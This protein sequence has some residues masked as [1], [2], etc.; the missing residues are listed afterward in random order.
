M[1][2]ILKN[3]KQ[4]NLTTLF[5]L[6]KF[7]RQMIYLFALIAIIVANL[8]VSPFALRLD[9]SQGQAYTLSSS[10]RKILKD[11][12]DVVNIKFFASSDLPTRILP[13]KNEV[14][15]LLNEYKKTGGKNIQLKILDPKKDTKAQDEAKE[16][17]VPELQFSQLEKDKYAV[18]SSYLGISLSYG[19]KKE[20]LP[21][22]TDVD[23]LEYNLTAAI[24]KMTRKELVKIGIL[25]YENVFDPQQDQ[26]STFKKILQQQFN[27]EFVN[28][29]SKSATAKIDPSIK[30]IM[31]FDTNQKEYDEQETNA[32]K[33]YVNNGGKAIFF[34]DGVWVSE[35]LTTQ[36]AKHNLFS[37]LKNFG[38]TLEKNLILSTTS[39][40]VSFGSQQVSFLAP[41]PFWVKSSN[42]N[43]KTSHFSNIQVLTYPWVSSLSL[44]KKSGGE[45]K[46]LVKTS[47]ESWQQKDDFTLNPQTILEPSSQDLREFIITA[48]SATSKKR[49]IVVV[50]SSRFVLER[51]LS[52]GSNNSEFV[53]NIVNN[54][55]SGGALAGIRQRAVAFYP[56][57]DL[58]ENQKDIFKYLDILFLP[59]LF[60]A[61]GG[62]RLLKRR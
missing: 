5:R 44:E 41:Y 47:K 43:A 29:S 2:E 54:L 24:Y 42:F 57:P 59:L 28:V 56:L 30:T 62:W 60:A 33:D 53:L 40:L 49:S 48:E 61:F 51:Y 31:I 16:I 13:L 14:T 55:A 32:I 25:G 8:I 46:E 10:T 21:Q 39:E 9:L 52:G 7:E 36:E 11:L 12:D 19:N 15:D 37:L 23:S 17:G 26:L 38:F 4:L 22:V 18:T 3:I 6:A 50:S 45:V 1:L 58:P 27:L 34:V 20:L 35:D